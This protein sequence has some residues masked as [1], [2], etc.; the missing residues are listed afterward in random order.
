[1]QRFG[2]RIGWDYDETL[3]T[4]MSGNP[5]WVAQVQAARA[6]SLLDELQAGAQG[7]RPS[8]VGGADELG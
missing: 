4:A 5:T 3:E 2:A 1:M 6:A 7:S 8:G